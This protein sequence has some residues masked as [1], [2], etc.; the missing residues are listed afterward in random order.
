ML[1]VKVTAAG[2]DIISASWL[3]L[4]WEKKT[5]WCWTPGQC[6]GCYHLAAHKQSR[7]V[8]VFTGTWKEWFKLFF[9]LSFFFLLLLQKS[10]SLAAVLILPV[11]LCVSL[12]WQSISEEMFYQLSN[13]LPQIFR[14]SSTLTLTSK[15]WWITK[16]QHNGFMWHSESDWERQ[17][18][19][20]S[21]DWRFCEATL[22][23]HSLLK[24]TLI[25]GGWNYSGKV[26]ITL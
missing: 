20:N 11:S 22:K 23:P 24:I 10:Q 9:F 26:V 15:H 12:C 5:L 19:V 18:H 3:L 17:V 1:H 21:T 2:A 6:R 8:Y 7:Y 14:V 13:M 16:V 25:T 4:P